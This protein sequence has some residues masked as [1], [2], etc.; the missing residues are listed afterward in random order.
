MPL[1]NRI[2]AVMHI[3]GPNLVKGIH[4]EGL[5]I[6]GHPE[7]FAQKYYEEGIDEIIY[8]DIVAS[9][10]GRNSLQD[11]IRRTT[12]N[13]FIPVTVG[14]GIASVKDAMDVM[15]AGADKVAINTAAHKRPELITEI[16]ER[17]GSQSVVAYIEARKGECM[18]DNAREKTGHLV[19]SW[20]REMVDRGAGELLMTSVERDGTG[21]GFES[22]LV[23]NAKD[24][25]VPVI[26]HGGFGKPEHGVS[27]FVSGA[28]AIAVSSAF[29][30]YYADRRAGGFLEGVPDFLHGKRD[31]EIAGCSIGEVKSAIKAAGFA[32]R[33]VY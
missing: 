27:A 15:S 5:R 33:E 22:G 25:R 26:F 6:L 4:L 23:E 17:L 2:V 32:V 21:G 1:S 31:R 3:K 19:E 10:Y 9:L 30:Y 18:T 7:Y 29:H 14:G 12:E 24:L 13:I 28:D 8:I 11:I 20:A 16:A